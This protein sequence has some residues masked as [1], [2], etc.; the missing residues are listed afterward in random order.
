ME[1]WDSDKGQ[2]MKIFKSYDE[3]KEV[4]GQELGV[5]N[6]LQVT[7]DQINIFAEATGD[8]QWIHTDPERAKT[9][10]PFKATI[11]HGYLTVSLMP[12][13]IVEIFDVDNTSMTINYGIDK[14]KFSQAVLVDSEVR[15][16]ASVAEV[17][18]VRGL[19]KTTLNVKMEIKGEKKPAFSGAITFL[20][21]YNA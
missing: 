19:V 5:S 9:E 6:Y 3:W 14:I 8:H 21:H 4:E 17:K 11:A 15:L 7:Q 16:N 20:Y 10:S 18:N 13:L 2:S 1:P 12:R